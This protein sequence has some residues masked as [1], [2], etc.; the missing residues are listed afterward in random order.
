MI[1]L[2]IYKYFIKL[3]ELLIWIV[4]PLWLITSILFLQ[5]IQRSK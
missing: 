1:E 4:I 5:L 2:L 3:A